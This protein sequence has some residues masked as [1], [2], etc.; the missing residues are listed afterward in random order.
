MRGFA[1]IAGVLWSLLASACGAPQA[2]SRQAMPDPL[3]GVDGGQLFDRGLQLARVGDH[4]R[5][6]QYFLASIDRGHPASEA[7]PHLLRACL[8][9]GRL[10]A[11]LHHAAPYLRDHPGEWSLRY[12]VATLHLGLGD[13]Q[14]ARSE[15]EQ[16]IRDA[17]SNPAAYY[18][19]GMLLR[20]SR[21]DPGAGGDYLRRYLELA[22]A[23]DH[24]PEVRAAL[25]TAPIE[26]IERVEPAPAEPE[27]LPAQT[28]AATESTSPT[29]E[30]SSAAA[31]AESTAAAVG[32]AG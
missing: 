12:L 32:D 4:L 17:P 2:T 21:P 14:A 18:T 15:L 13:S 8:A 25:N 29:P 7:M 10:S 11:A 9:G 30:R 5:A 3:A 19:L 27:Q 1:T 26:R 16:V 20:D 24:A 6:E 28:P 23:G 31:P 22:P